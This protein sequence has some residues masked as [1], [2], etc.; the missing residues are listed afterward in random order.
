MDKRNLPFR[1]VLKQPITTAVSAPLVRAMRGTAQGDMR[2]ILLVRV[3]GSRTRRL[4][5]II[6]ETR[7]LMLLN[8]YVASTQLCSAG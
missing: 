2:I 5:E 4:F 3:L 8:E 6:R 7:S 1:V